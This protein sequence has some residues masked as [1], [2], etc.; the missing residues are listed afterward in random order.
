M[1]Q[2]DPAG[3]IKNAG[4][5][6]PVVVATATTTNGASVDTLGWRWALVR[7]QIG[8]V[9]GTTTGVSAVVAASDTTSGT[10][11]A[12][13]GATFTAATLLAGATSLVGRIDCTKL[14]SSTQRWIRPQITTTGA[15]PS[16]PVAASVELIGADDT[17]SQTTVYQF[18]I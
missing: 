9:A 8:T 3:N 14:T 11:T 15:A 1:S 4:S 2:F 17:D 13:T 7:V 5:I 10:F 12:I 18:T 16:V 6:L